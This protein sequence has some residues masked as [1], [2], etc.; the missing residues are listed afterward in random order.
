DVYKSQPSERDTLP[1]VSIKS[2]RKQN[3]KD[4]QITTQAA[5]RNQTP[6]IEINPKIRYKTRNS[7]QSSPL[8]F[9]SPSYKMHEKVCSLHKK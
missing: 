5:K 4:T 1:Q 9:P 2:P 3:Q 6:Q 8:F 7:P